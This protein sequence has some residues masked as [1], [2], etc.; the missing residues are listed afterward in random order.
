LR[1]LRLVDLP[2]ERS[3]PACARPFGW[4]R[5]ISPLAATCRSSTARHNRASLPPVLARQGGGTGHRFVW[6]PSETLNTTD[7]V[8]VAGSR[9]SGTTDP[10]HRVS[11][12]P[13]S[14]TSTSYASRGCRCTS[15]TTALVPGS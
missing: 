1:T 3:L 8:H 15:T 2:F 4:Q 7:L 14:T 5:A 13:W 11:P 9:F 12:D 10:H 6:A